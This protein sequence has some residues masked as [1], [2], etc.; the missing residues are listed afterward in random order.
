MGLEGQ[1]HHE[2]RHKVLMCN[3]H[4]KSPKEIPP[5]LHHENPKKRHQKSPKRENRRDNKSLEEPRRIFNT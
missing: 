5:K 4:T 1:G 3:S 2:K